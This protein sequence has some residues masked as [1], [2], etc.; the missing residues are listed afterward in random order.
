MSQVVLTLNGR[1]YRMSCGEGEEQRLADLTAHVQKHI[2][3]LVGDFGQVGDDRLLL[4][5]ALKIADEL[6]DARGQPDGEVTPELAEID[7]DG[8]KR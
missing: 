3:I 5:A 8:A 7:N 6:W 1:T 4:M 2:D